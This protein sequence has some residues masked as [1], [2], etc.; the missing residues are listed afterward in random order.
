M[1]YLKKITSK[2][3]FMEN[4]KSENSEK[5]KKKKKKKKKIDETLPPCLKAPSAEHSRSHDIDEP[6]N[7]SRGGETD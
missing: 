4:S 7:D 5:Q 3:N 1:N 6:C 2:G